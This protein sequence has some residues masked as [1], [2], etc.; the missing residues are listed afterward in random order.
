[1]EIVLISHFP[2]EDGRVRFEGFDVIQIRPRLQVIN[3]VLIVP[4]TDDYR[5]SGLADFVQHGF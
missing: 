1:M 3:T 4:K 2:E 5:Q